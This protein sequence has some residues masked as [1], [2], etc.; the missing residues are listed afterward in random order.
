MNQA[1]NTVT[2]TRVSSLQSGAVCCKLQTTRKLELI[3]NNDLRQF[4]DC[5]DQFAKSTCKLPINP[6]VSRVSA[7]FPVCTLVPLY[8]RY[9]KTHHRLFVGVGLHRTSVV[10]V[11][12]AVVDESEWEVRQ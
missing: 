11:D 8:L 3:K 4:A 2:H 5:R 1:T 6:V 7:V 12:K 10:S 9:R